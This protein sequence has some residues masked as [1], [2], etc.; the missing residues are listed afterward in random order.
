MEVLK[1]PF[2]L[3]LHKLLIIIKYEL[4]GGEVL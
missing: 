1:E 4:N 2:T 3:D